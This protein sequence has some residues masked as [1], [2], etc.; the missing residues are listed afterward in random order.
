MSEPADSG[1]VAVG[2]TS[3]QVP[4]PTAGALIRGAR[5]AAGLHIG[6][7]AVMLK[8]PVRKL[9]ALE[10]NRFELLTDAVFTRALAAS[11]CKTLKIDPA[12]VLQL[13]P[14]YVT[15]RLA[16]DARQRHGSFNPPGAG[17]WS[18][19]LLSRLSRPVVAV[20]GVLLAATIA[21]LLW[22]AQSTLTVA[23]V[24]PRVSASAT[25]ASLSESAAV[26][27]AAATV[28]PTAAVAATGAPD[29]S[30][31]RTGP[32]LEAAMRPS[33]SSAAAPAAAVPPQATPSESGVA[34]GQAV[35]SFRA[36]ATSWVE[37]TDSAGLVRLRKTLVG[38]ESAGAAGLLPLSVVVGRADST[39]V[40][41]R[42]QAFDLVP[43][44][45]DNV[46]RFKV[47]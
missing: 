22:P 36:R 28:A 45:K 32:V 9:E 44:S 31:V 10:S 8:V 13:L 39:E 17:G 19:P 27:P 37:V 42:G 18:L 4:H 47:K 29:P 25:R 23:S 40:V 41:I 16:I 26:A 2:G 14:G 7:L 35:V 46:A 33:P 5:E 21:L 11:V 34:P 15:P 1:T 24:D 3:G 30:L 6:A 38:G 43:V 12:P 20:A